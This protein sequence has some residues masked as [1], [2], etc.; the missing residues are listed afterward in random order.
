MTKKWIN[1]NVVIAIKNQPSIFSL[2]LKLI[3]IR[4]NS[5]GRA[6]VNPMKSEIPEKMN[7]LVFNFE[8]VSVKIFG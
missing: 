3:P 2:P 4:E 6:F 7:T 5:V 8:V 1:K